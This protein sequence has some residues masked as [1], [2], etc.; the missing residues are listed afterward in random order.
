MEAR[1]S[2]TSTN[3]PVEVTPSTASRIRPAPIE[4]AFPTPTPPQRQDSRTSEKKR[5]DSPALTRFMSIGKSSPAPRLHKSVE[6]LRTDVSHFKGDSYQTLDGSENRQRKDI[7]KKNSLYFENIFATRGPYNSAKE[8]VVRDSTIIVELSL[9]HAAVLQQPS[10]EEDSD[11]SQTPRELDPRF[12]NDFRMVVSET[13]RKSASDI[14]ISATSNVYIITG[15]SFDPAYL[16]TVTALSSEIAAAKNIRASM[17]MQNFLENKLAI[18]QNR[19]VIR[20][21]AIPETNLATNGTTVQDEI[22]KLEQ[23]EKRAGGLS[24]RQSNRTSKRSTMI[25]TSETPAELEQ[26]ESSTPILVDNNF[27]AINELPQRSTSS[28]RAMRAKRSVLN[29]WKKN[30]F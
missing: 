15:D 23:A 29:F 20:F 14:F 17:R 26:S 3:E 19:G 18:P 28:A 16:I 12:L 6:A 7:S 10:Y 30:P 4:N 1:N 27:A 22:E 13:Y 9:N 24:S 5:P 11:T 8:R 25:N 2:E 21:H